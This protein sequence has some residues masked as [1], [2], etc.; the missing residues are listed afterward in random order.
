[1]A[2]P[3]DGFFGENSPGHFV[4]IDTLH[5]SE[6]KDKIFL[7]GAGNLGLAKRRKSPKT[8]I[9]CQPLAF[10]LIIE[11][12]KMYQSTENSMMNAHVPITLYQLFRLLALLS[13]ISDHLSY[14]LNH[15]INKHIGLHL[16]SYIYADD[17]NNYALVYCLSQDVNFI[18]TDHL[19]PFPQHLKQC[20]LG[21]QQVLSNF[22]TA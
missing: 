14:S 1:M 3:T 21:I 19:L 10:F 4:D 17:N 2:T 11:I 15:H 16:S 12:F 8:M 13:F 7:E 9:S 5:P 20:L 22:F 18:R 6:R